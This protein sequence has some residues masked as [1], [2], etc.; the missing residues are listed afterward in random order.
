MLLEYRFEGQLFHSLDYDPEWEVLSFGTSKG[1]LLNYCLKV[2]IE[3]CYLAEDGNNSK[4]NTHHIIN[5]KD[6]KHVK[7]QMILRTPFEQVESKLPVYKV[8]HQ[9]MEANT[10]DLKRLD[11]KLAAKGLAK[12]NENGTEAS[13]VSQQVEVTNFE[14][15]ASGDNFD[16]SSEAEEEEAK[17]NKA[18]PD[19]Q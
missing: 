15:M 14:K 10:S 3:N 17:E 6:V 8:S 16:D 9:N 1:Q 13:A 5:D 2:G 19:V 7:D 18:D 12:A 4:Q 11:G